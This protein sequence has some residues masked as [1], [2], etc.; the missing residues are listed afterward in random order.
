MI[1]INF[2]R[3][4]TVEILNKYYSDQVCDD[5][6]I[7]S[8]ARTASVMHG[9]NLVSKQYGNRLYAGIP[10]D[11]TTGVPAFLPDEGTQLV[12]FLRCNNPLFFNFTNSPVGGLNGNLLYFTNNNDNP[13][14]NGKLVLTA[15]VP[16]Y[17]G[18]TAYNIGDLVLSGGTVY[19]AVQNN[20]GVALTDTANWLAVDT[21]SYVSAADVKHIHKDPAQQA[22]DPNDLVHFL[23]DADYSELLNA[24]DICAVLNIVNDSTLANGY[25]LLTGGKVTL[26][27]AQKL[28]TI[29]F[30]N[31]ATKWKYIMLPA[32]TGVI[33]QTAPT[34]GTLAFPGGPAANQVT[35]AYPLRFNDMQPAAN[36][37]TFQLTTASGQTVTPLPLASPDIIKKDTSLYAEIYLNY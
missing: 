1:N 30:L 37:Y 19:E 22:A 9:Y 32:S 17:S 8:S 31:R 12:F 16:A 11:A 26:P 33:K 10:A 15:P 28:F 7:T 20:T 14:V 23:P 36:A 24:T 27:P 3:L 5:F 21:D 4:F 18:A 6:V 34:T 25:N 29:Y 2:I 35:S 13:P